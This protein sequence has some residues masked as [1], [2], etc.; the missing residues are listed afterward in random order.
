MLKRFLLTLLTTL[1]LL[2]AMATSA[3]QPAV[4]RIATF[5]YVDKGQVKLGG[6]SYYDRVIN[7]GWLDA[8]LAKRGIKLQ[9]VPIAGNDTGPVINEAFASKRIDFATYG[10]LPSII[11]N[12]AGI[13][14]RVVV[15]NG[16]GTDVVLL[17]PPGSTAHSLQDLKGK[18]ISIHRSRPWELSMVKLL[19]QQGLSE[20]DFQIVNMQP[21]AGAAALASG[22]VDALFD[23]GNSGYLL[24]DK[25]IG[26]IIWSSRQAPSTRIRAELWGTDDFIAQYP[27]VTQIV[28]EAFVRAQHW[29]SLPENQET[30]L[31]AATV[32][33]TPEAVVRHNY[34]DPA[35]SWK[36]HWSPRFD[37]LLYTQ[38]RGDLDTAYSTGRVRRKL[39]VD[40]LVAPRFVEQALKDQ[41]LEDYWQPWS[42]S[43][44]A[45]H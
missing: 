6:S 44:G 26:K 31:K 33:G 2:F 35:I 25:N 23:I 32:N 42:S 10:D 29:A 39:N 37:E 8:E 41:H 34:D 14:T 1:A 4:V 9:W 13:H 27:D 5:A 15:P 22:N 28:A 38:Y 3:A 24:A 19:A 30:V 17:V 16:H 40:D 12:A 21:Q 7:E 20:K 36:D 11:L 45:S 18:R 43:V